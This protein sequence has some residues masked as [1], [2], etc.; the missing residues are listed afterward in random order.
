MLTFL[1][2]IGVCIEIGLCVGRG[3]DNGLGE[4]FF[5][6]KNRPLCIRE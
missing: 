4:G 6:G 2:F 3:G 1:L 5:M